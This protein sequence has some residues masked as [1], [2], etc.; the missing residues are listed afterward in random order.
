MNAILSLALLLIILGFRATLPSI[1]ARFNQ[2]GLDDYQAGRLSSALSNY[3][4]AIALRPDYTEAHYYLGVLYEDLQKIDQA[5]AEYELIVQSDST[6]ATSSQEHLILL[7]A[8]NNLGRLYLLKNSN[9]AAWIPLERGLRLVKADVTQNDA[10]VQYEH[11]K[12]LKNMG[13]VRLQQQHYLDAQKW[14][15]QAIAL[16]PEIE[17]LLKEVGGHAAPFCL[18]A[19]VLEAQQQNAETDWIACT[20]YAELDNPDEAQWVG[21]ARQRLANP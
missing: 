17:H 19:Q 5:I 11:Y 20:R 15:Q 21:L 7:Q 1:A 13:W 3:Q 2:N 8:H 14:L 12:L 4:Q 9:Q 18:R 6:A 10:N 16:Q